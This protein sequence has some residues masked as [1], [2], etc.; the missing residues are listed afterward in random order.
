MGN[1]KKVDCN[2]SLASWRKHLTC[3]NSFA[4]KHSVKLEKASDLFQRLC[5][6][7][8]GF[9]RFLFNGGEGNTVEG[10]N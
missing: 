1:N 5:L 7:T 4:L 9:F 3:S 8:L 2:T 10:I 6:E